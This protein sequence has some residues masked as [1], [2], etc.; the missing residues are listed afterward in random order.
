MKSEKW[1][2]QVM[3]R[4]LVCAVLCA[5][6][7]SSLAAQTFQNLYDFS[8]GG[9]LG[10]Y[11][12]TDQLAQ[13][14][15]GNLYGTTSSGGSYGV[16]TIFM[17]T[18]SGTYTDLVEF[19]GTN[20][21]EPSAG[22][23]LASDGNF[24]GAAFFGGK[25]GFGTLF[26][27]T[28]PSTLK[29]LHSFSAGS[30]GW[31]PT[32]PP[33]E[34]KD[35]N[36]YGLTFPGTPYRVTLPAGKYGS[37]GTDT[38]GK[39]GSDRLL[40]ASDGNLYGNT[41]N[42][43]NSNMGTVFQM[44]TTTGAI[45]PIYQFSGLD[46]DSPSGALVEETDG[47]LYGTTTLGGANNTGEV[48][49]MTLSGNMVFEYSFDSDI[50]GTNTDGAYPTGVTAGWFGYLYGVSFHGGTD[51]AGTLFEITESEIF[52]PLFDFTGGGPVDGG[53]PY[54]TLLRHTNGNYYGLTFLGGAGNGNFYSLTPPNPLIS[55]IIEGPVFVAPGV[56]VEFLGNELTQT[57]QVE[58]AGVPAQFQ[59]GS[60]T[61]LT[62]QVPMAAI[63]GPVTATLATG[64]Q[65]QT[66]ESIHILPLITNLDPPSGA[67]GTQVGI[68]GGGFAGA[69]EV[70][71]GGVAA[72][73]FTV[74]GPTLIQAI[75]P[76]GAETGAVTVITPNG[77]AASKQKFRVKK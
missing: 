49:K 36:L 70:S 22:L 5:L 65:L 16:G 40:L 6:A 35:G 61:Y 50:N 44:I 77:T 19:N 59:I 26:R 68:V 41:Q 46:G 51:G 67:V 62:V 20:G 72:A 66:L 17:V 34:A 2:R 25:Y 73:N 76:T 71:F 37:L 64:L 3:L 38:P 30:D 52:T 39:P 11:P 75:V 47:Y 8:C 9:I 1:M 33:I 55:L 14:K 42:G 60:D 56:A 21:S 13:G 12:D 43:G 74:V 57:I 53:S 23:T 69:T 58:F 29:V 18:P 54:T 32:A 10:C 15:D 63:D 27:F 28:P 45:T 48:F 24:Y 7:A 31:S 4:A